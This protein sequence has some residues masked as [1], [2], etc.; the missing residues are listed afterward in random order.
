MFFFDLAAISESFRNL[1]CRVTIGFA[2]AFVLFLVLAVN[3]SGAATTIG[4]GPQGLTSFRHNGA[5]FLSDGK[6]FVTLVDFSGKASYPHPSGSTA[7]GGD[8]RCSITT[9][10]NWGTLTC[11]YSVSGDR[12]QANINVQNRTP[13]PVREFHV[14]LLKLRPS[15]AEAR[16]QF[17]AGLAKD[18]LEGPEV[19]QIPYGTTTVAIA[20]DETGQLSALFARPGP[21]GVIVIVGNVARAVLPPLKQGYGVVWKLRRLTQASI[22]PPSGA[23]RYAISFAFGQAGESPRIIFPDVFKRFAARFPPGLNWPD[24]RPIGN[25]FLAGHSRNS[26]PKPGNPR[27]WF[28]NRVPVD[29]RS[30]EG[31]KQ[32]HTLLLQKADKTVAIAKK[33]NAQGVI[34]WD[35]EGE[36]LHAPQYIGD[37]R[38]LPPEMQGVVDEF[39]RRFTDAGLR[40]G[41]TLSGWRLVAS[42]SGVPLYHVW[43]DD[44]DTVAKSLEDR[45]EY[46]RRRWGCTLFY[47]DAN[48]DMS[49][50]TGVSAF[51][52]LAR[53]HPDILLVPEHGTIAY[54]GWT[55]P[56][57]FVGRKRECGSVQARW[58]YPRAFNVIAMNLVSPPREGPL[59][60]EL[61]ARVKEGDVLMFQS[62][63]NSPENGAVL[64][65]YRQAWGS[66]WQPGRP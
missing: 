20:N 35:V 66:R 19:F 36:D 33:M 40:C 62:H 56:Y 22:V 16:G 27:F 34:V 49:W 18:G 58:T 3:D 15:T 52:T 39:F 37:P 4:C 64:D 8:G 11:S 61:V 31:I 53:R 24:R 26:I 38:Y 13:N 55:A 29:I 14:Q 42:S 1:R 59:W 17:A 2:L 25:F 21:D 6:C 51:R 10:Y 65:I 23:A 32:F 48:G 60:Q 63:F 12:L 47:I 5:E 46:V 41:V 57:C 30:A 43:S 50:P 44:P 28:L 9:T 45:I 54:Y 7:S